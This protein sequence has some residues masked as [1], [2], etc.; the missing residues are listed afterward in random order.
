MYYHDEA[1]IL[2]ALPLAWTSLAPVDPFVSLAAGRSAFRL[3]DL[4][5]LARLLTFL[6]GELEEVN[7]AHSPTDL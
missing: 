3:L 1:G 6:A 7:D 5:E 2:R 4:L